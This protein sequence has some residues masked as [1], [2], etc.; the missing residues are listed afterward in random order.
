MNGGGSG[1]VNGNVPFEQTA[2]ECCLKHVCQK[3]HD[4]V[5]DVEPRLRKV[6]ERTR[7][8]S[9]LSRAPQ[10]D[11]IRRPVLGGGAALFGPHEFRCQNHDQSGVNISF[12]LS[13]RNPILFFLNAIISL[14]YLC[15]IFKIFQIPR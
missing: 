2:L 4:S 13:P 9:A 15:R 7:H 8:L 6:G 12:N 5:R 1:L 11:F 3:L 10:Q 14:T